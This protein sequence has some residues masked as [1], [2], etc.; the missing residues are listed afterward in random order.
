MSDK[1]LILEIPYG[2]LG[3]HLFHSPIP[4]IAKEHYNFDKVFIS[5]KSISR[6]PDNL[7]LTWEY[8][9]YVDGYTDEPGIKLSIEQITAKEFG[10]YGNLLDHLV[11]QIWPDFQEQFLEPEIYYQPKF[12]KEFEQAIFDPNYLS[13]VGEIE[14]KSMMNYLA[15]KKIKLDAI[16]KIRTDKALYIPNSTTT[17]VE[18][19]TLEDFCDLIY[20]AEAVYCLT[21]GTATIAAG[22]NKAATVFYGENQSH[23]FRHSKLHNYQLVKN[24]PIRK[25]INYLKQ[26]IHAK[27]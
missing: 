8:N 7:K 10:L 19:P 26:F 21:S 15:K 27:K 17:F 6:H 16:M 3:D 20:S 24:N 5:N 1:T 11:K 22:L 2:G 25:S 4:R 23:W 18:T 12:R 13:W 9:P 14:K